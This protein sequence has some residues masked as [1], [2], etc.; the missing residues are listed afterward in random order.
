MTLYIANAFAIGMLPDGLSI[1]VKTLSSAE[2]AREE[3]CSGHAVRSIVGHVDTAAVFS[4]QLKI[5][6]SYNRESVT[7]EDG[8]LMLVGQL[9]GGRL[10]EGVTTLPEGFQ[11]IWRLVRAEKN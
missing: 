11:I 3:I 8:D 9:A 10:P 6:V 1:T 4:E 2:D 5:P 7:L